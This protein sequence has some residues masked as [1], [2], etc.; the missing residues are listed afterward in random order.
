MNVKRL[1]LLENLVVGAVLSE[2][3]SEMIYLFFREI[4]G[5]LAKLMPKSGVS[6]AENAGKLELKEE[7]PYASE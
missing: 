6:A 1:F 5:K 3:V 2:P 7:I 4:T